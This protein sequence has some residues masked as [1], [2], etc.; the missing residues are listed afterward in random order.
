MSCSA[1]SRLSVKTTGPLYHSSGP[2]ASYIHCLTLHDI[3]LHWIK[4]FSSIVVLY[5]F[6]CLC[7]W[8]L[9]IGLQCSIN[10][11]LNLF[12]SW[13]SL[14]SCQC[15]TWCTACQLSVIVCS[16]DGHSAASAPRL[17]FS[18]ESE[19]TV[20]E[21]HTAILSCFFYGRSV[22]FNLCVSHVFLYS[23]KFCD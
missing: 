19:L 3:A 7:C 18:S 12:M 15:Q 9:A 8:F 10:L 13:D 1:H 17:A 11:N 6:H 4:F 5:Y 23:T 20:L 22:F 14:P 16:L 2:A 21:G